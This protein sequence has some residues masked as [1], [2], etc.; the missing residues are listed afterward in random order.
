MRNNYFTQR[1]KGAEKNLQRANFKTKYEQQ[2]TSNKQL[3]SKQ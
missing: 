1:R 3:K 2:E